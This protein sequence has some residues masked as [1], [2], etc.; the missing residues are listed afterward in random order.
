MPETSQEVYQCP[1][2][3]ALASVESDAER[4]CSACGFELGKPVKVSPRAV[5]QHSSQRASFVQRDVSVRRNAGGRVEPVLPADILTVE[6]IQPENEDRNRDEVISDDGNKKVVRR[7]KKRK[8]GRVAPL[9]FL[10]GWAI[11]VMLVVI[12]VK[13]QRSND[14]T[15]ADAGELAAVKLRAKQAKVDKF[16]SEEIGECQKNFSAFA[17]ARAAERSQ[18]VRHPT[19]LAPIMGDYYS[20]YALPW[21]VPKDGQ[22][23]LQSMNLFTPDGE[24]VI[25][26]VFGVVGGAE[27]VADREVA[28]VRED[29]RWVIDW[30][31]FVRHSTMFWQDFIGDYGEQKQ[32]VFRLHVRRAS[33]SFEGTRPTLVL[34]FFPPMTEGSETWDRGSEGIVVPLDEESGLRMHHILNRS[35]ER[36]LGDSIFGMKEPE[37]LRRVRVRLQWEETPDGRRFVKLRKVFAGNW[38]GEGFEET[39]P[40]F[41]EE[42]TP[43]SSEGSKRSPT[44]S[45]G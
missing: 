4:V 6:E 25:E 19:R 12:F 17:A 7:R 30:E 24:P 16:L 44:S 45:G 13:N 10:G 42:S 41:E 40:E 27:P 32:G 21:K 18:F 9:L 39:F 36:E 1:A 3:G 31:S 26:A 38:Y 11:V 14:D 20:N 2:C 8:R 28:F 29:G 35:E 5:S 15:E 23:V 33:G 34:K 37:E 22:L 43:S